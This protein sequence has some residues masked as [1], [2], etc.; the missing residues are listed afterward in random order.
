MVLFTLGLAAVLFGAAQT[1][2]QPGKGKGPGKGPGAGADIE[3]LERELERLLEQIQDTKAKLAQ[4][5]ESA[6]KDDGQRGP[7]GQFGPKGKGFGKGFQGKGGFGGKG[8]GKKGFEGFKKFDPMKK[9]GKDG[10]KEKLDPETIRERYEYYKN[11]YDALPK[12]KGKGFE[13]KKGKGFDGKKKEPM[14]EPKR[15]GDTG[16]AKGGS[17]SVEARIDALIRE[18][19]A[20][21][22]EV[23]GDKKK[24]DD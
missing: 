6:K 11:L 16:D 20:L 17:R 8:F 23:R 22:R 10:E 3:R 4:A 1:D 7:K 9:F 18:L 2:A 12:G 13:A 5:R 21:R 14:P 24:R 19:E 15:K